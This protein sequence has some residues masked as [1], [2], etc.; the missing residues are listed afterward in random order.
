MILVDSSVWIDFFRGIDAPHVELLDA[1][2]GVE[3]VVIGDLILTE[4]LQGIVGER[5]FKEAQ[6]MLLRLECLTLGGQAVAL[7]SA[8]NYR[9][10]RE[11]GVTVRKTVDSLIATRCIMDGIRLLHNDRDFEPFARYLGL[12]EVR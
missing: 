1:A 12:R 11:K 3:P 5:D 7:Q 6:K 8:Q 10:L 4:V 9:R 2:L